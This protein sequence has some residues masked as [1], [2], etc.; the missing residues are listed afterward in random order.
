MTEPDLSK[1]IKYGPKSLYLFLSSCLHTFYTLFKNLNNFHLI[2][3]FCQLMVWELMDID[4]KWRPI[5]I[6]PSGPPYV[7]Q[8]QFQTEYS[9]KHKRAL[10][11]QV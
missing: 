10:I 3:F 8:F 2:D 7:P 5:V 11:L 4:Q 1:K 9:Q 6:W